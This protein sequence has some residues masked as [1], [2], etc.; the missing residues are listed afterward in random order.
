MKLETLV[1]EIEVE[2]VSLVEKYLKSNSIDQFKDEKLEN[3]NRL[4]M[5]VIFHDIPINLFNLIEL[6]PGDSDIMNITK[7]NYFGLNRSLFKYIL[8]ISKM[9]MS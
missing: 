7:M 1:E 8:N 9:N 4:L 6:K 3:V 2:N 5:A